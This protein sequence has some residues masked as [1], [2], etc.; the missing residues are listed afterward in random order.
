MLTK[1]YVAT[2]EDLKEY[3]SGQLII[4]REDGMLGPNRSESTLTRALS[5][6]IL[7]RPGLVG[8]IKFYAVTI[9]PEG[10]LIAVSDTQ[11]TRYYWL[12]RKR[13]TVI[14]GHPS[15]SFEEAWTNLFKGLLADTRVNSVRLYNVLYVLFLRHFQEEGEKR[16]FAIEGVYHK[17]DFTASI[18][19]DPEQPGRVVIS[20]TY[21]TVKTRSVPIAF[22]PIEA[23]HR[24]ARKQGS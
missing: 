21:G 17:E 22:H 20:S 3:T 7:V 8:A 6:R 12:A 1:G 15:R 5:P 19:W 18:E 24:A 16:T 23:T 14:V 10:K 11:Q 13:E 4:G 9:L 2:A